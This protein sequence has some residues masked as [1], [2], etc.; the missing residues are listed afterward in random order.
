M[1]PHEAREILMRY[2]D[3]GSDRE[4]P[5]VAAALEFAATDSELSKWLEGHR[6]FQRG[7][8]QRLRGIA[9]PAGLREQ[10]LSEK[11]RALSRLRPG[12]MPWVIASLA[13][14]LLLA[15]LAVWRPWTND[16]ENNFSTFRM[17]MVKVSLRGYAM[18]WT[19]DSDSELRQHFGAS[20]LSS[21][22][23]TP[24]GLQQLPLMGGAVMTWRSQPA[25]MICYGRGTDPEL[26][27]FVIDSQSIPDP[28]TGS[29][30]VFGS[31]NETGTLTWAKDGMTYLLVGNRDEKGL[32]ELLEKGV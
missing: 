7:M 23:A 4:D 32:R 1:N 18:D 17:R 27:L 8:Q 21:A 20:N 11:P 26:W 3:Q 13:G 29:T 15:S 2:R 5:D 10:I 14:I 30:A 9:P 25:A 24:P 22:W 16:T 28:P 19:T 31:V 6:R 12:M